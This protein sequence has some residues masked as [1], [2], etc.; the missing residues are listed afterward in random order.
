MEVVFDGETA[1]VIPIS[2]CS[3]PARLYRSRPLSLHMSAGD[4]RPTLTLWEPSMAWELSATQTASNSRRMYPSDFLTVVECRKS[5]LRPDEVSG[6]CAGLHDHTLS[7]MSFGR[8]ERRA[9][10][11]E[12]PR[13]L[14]LGPIII[15]NEDYSAL[16]YSLRQESSVLGHEMKHVPYSLT[17]GQWPPRTSHQR[18]APR[19]PCN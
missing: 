13:P 14:N 7:H 18:R 15:R 6:G 5:H 12:L 10:L 2:T 17:R 9:S 19:R 11:Q 16:A 1:S 8:S 4:A 3:N